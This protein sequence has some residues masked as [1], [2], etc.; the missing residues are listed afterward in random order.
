MIRCSGPRLRSLRTLVVL[1]VVGLACARPAPPATE[2]PAA[3]PRAG[4]HSQASA[5]AADALRDLLLEGR[6]EAAN[7]LVRAQPAESPGDDRWHCLAAMAALADNDA[8]ALAR[9]RAALPEGSGWALLLRAQEQAGKLPRRELAALVT[10]A[11]ARLGDHPD[12]VWLHAQVL[13]LQSDEDGLAALAARPDLPDSVRDFVHAKR[14]GMTFFRLSAA[15]LPM[16]PSHEQVQALVTQ[17]EQT[18]PSGTLA[19]ARA[20]E[21][22]LELQR[23]DAALELVERALARRP[24]VLALT[25]LRARARVAAARQDAS[26]RAAA[27]AELV[28][29]A[30]RHRAEPEALAQL[31]DGLQQLGATEAAQAIYDD[32]R[33]RFP[34][35]R[36]VERWDSEL[37]AV[38]GAVGGCRM[39]LARGELPPADELAQ[40]RAPVDAFFDRP[41]LRDLS[42]RNSTAAAL[43]EF[44]QCDPRA[45][46]QRVEAV[47]RAVLAAPFGASYDAQAA[48]LLAKR[49][50][51]LE[52]AR[53]LAER[54][55]ALADDTPP[56]FALVA[57][58]GELE[59]L[60]RAMRGLAHH[61]RGLVQLRAGR[62]EDARA[63]VSRAHEL[64]PTHPDIAL[65]AAELA[66]R[67]GEVHRAEQILARSI[68]Q[69]GAPARACR[70]RLQQLVLTRGGKAKD[71]DRTIARLERERKDERIAAVLAARAAAP[72]PLAPFELDLRGG[73]RIS[74]EALRGRVTVVIATEPWC[75]ACR[76]EA[77]ELAKLQQRYRGR[78]DV[79]FVVVTSDPD[80][81]AALHGTAGFRAP[82]ARDDGWRS[83]VGINGYPTH[84]FIDAAG[85][86]VYRETGNY[87]EMHFIHPALIEALRRGR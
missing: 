10:E 45:P 71:L 77:P 60:R 58:P 16:R 85:R 52:L 7:A 53:E 78:K 40:A 51:D 68:V 73:G 61:A 20:A 22:W 74:S 67:D 79:Q 13:D 59:E 11:R 21:Q 42:L 64:W 44:L 38:F 46:L 24:D 81:I 35:A 27:I 66:E 18:A 62:V 69:E 12:A 55:L 19:V 28:A 9:H 25:V 3:E 48:V 84:L 8:Q 6:V 39:A 43:I 47:A 4:E 50:G 41:R 76:L 5:R 83:M 54:A 36:A 34:D 86:E 82:I 37:V 49:S 57:T 56:G 33:L 29:L 14:I 26:L 31:V 80:G 87:R 65:L 15:P 32:V 30:D 23:A 72:Q 70:E 2:R 17:A 75:T 1:A 63:D